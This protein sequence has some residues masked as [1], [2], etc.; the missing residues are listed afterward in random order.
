[1]IKSIAYRWQAERHGGLSGRTRKTL[2]K[3]AVGGNAT[4]IPVQ[5]MR[6]PTKPG[7]RFVRE[8]KGQPIEVL[9]G[10]NG[11]FIW[12]G[13]AYSSLSAIAR[14]VTGTRRNGPA[15]FGLREA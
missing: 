8:W 10:D 4:S 6:R 2:R 12:N 9:A 1:M 15:F 11:T 5:A 7:T 3:I 14:K 13:E